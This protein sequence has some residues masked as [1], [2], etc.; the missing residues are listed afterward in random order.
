MGFSSKVA[1]KLGLKP[2]EKWHTPFMQLDFSLGKGYG[3][4]VW[5]E[6]FAPEGLGKTTLTL[7]SSSLYLALN[8]NAYLLYLDVEKALDTETIQQFFYQENV[9]VDYEDGTLYVDGEDRG[10]V[11][12]PDTYEQIEEITEEFIRWCAS[13]KKKGLIVWDSL[14]SAVTE[15]IVKEGSDKIG[16]R[17]KAIQDYI[18]RFVSDFRRTPITLLVINQIRDKINTTM[19]MGQDKSLG[20]MV[21]DT[22]HVPG[23]RAHKF[24]SFQSLMF[25]SGKKWKYG[26]TNDKLTGKVTKIIPTKNK[27]APDRRQVDLIKIDDYGFS[28]IVSLL[29]FLKSQKAMQGT[30][31]GMAFNDPTLNKFFGKKTKLENFVEEIINNPD[32]L[33]AFHQ[34][35]FNHLLVYY[36]EQKRINRYDKETQKKIILLDAFKLKRFL[37]YVN[38]TNPTIE[39]LKEE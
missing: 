39:H 30:M 32:L 28:N 8:D 7:Q 35:C 11:L 38:S 18:E 3:E 17:A 34:V 2:I 26:S 20:G 25:V 23:G 36:K 15:K 6:L 37:D 1:K 21:D 33:D 10:R 9:E 27:Q 16:F 22:Y 24:F 13:E 29:E 4:G 14:V 5:I 19:F 31:A 12:M